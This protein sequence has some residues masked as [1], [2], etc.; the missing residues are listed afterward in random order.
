MYPIVLISAIAALVAGIIVISYWV[1]KK[2]TEKLR[3]VAEEIGLTF[4]PKGDSNT[5]KSLSGFHLFSQGHS[6]KLKNLM[7]GEAN[8]IEVKI[9]DYQYTTGSGRSSH[10]WNQTIVCFYS[11][12]LELPG[13]AL[14]P[15]TFFDRI[16][17]L[18]GYQD[19]D[20]D[21]HPLF[22][23]S[24]LL[25]GKNEQAIRN[26]FQESV[27]S[28]YEDHSGLSTEGGGN[29]LIFYRASKKVKP[30]NIRSLLEEGFEVLG[31]FKPRS[32]TSP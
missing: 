1:E 21:T 26:L 4:Y 11:P 32:A 19:I 3:L 22:S 16:G 27:L 24:Y 6:K 12:E 13:F 2:R 18:F 23:K 30:E 10:T 14:R 15:E 20:F 8:D 31:L 28:Y 25:R 5:F 29:Y 7:L 9:F 17:S